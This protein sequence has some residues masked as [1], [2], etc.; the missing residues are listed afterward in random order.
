M[1]WNLIEPQICEAKK[2]EFDNINDNGNANGVNDKD[3]INYIY[4]I[5]NNNN[6]G[7][8][9]CWINPDFKNK[10]AQN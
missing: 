5:D 3:N 9:M 6:Y 2:V 4:N 7:L 10:N 8:W 1:E